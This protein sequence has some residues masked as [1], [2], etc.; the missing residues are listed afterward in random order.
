MTKNV[1]VMIEGL[2]YGEE[3]DRI[4]TKEIG[5]YHFQNGKHYI[6]YEEKM[7]GVEGAIK[8][9]IKVAPDQIV[10]T[11]IGAANTTLSFHPREVT[12]TNYQTPYGDIQLRIKTTQ[13]QVE[14]DTDEI[15]INLAY[16][17]TANGNPLSE[18]QTIIRILSQELV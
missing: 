2:Q 18:N 17:L 6:R 9:M 5:T 1:V 13:I 11:K 15:L 10:M 12:S 8:N 16:R 14:E 7:E 4:A 3:N